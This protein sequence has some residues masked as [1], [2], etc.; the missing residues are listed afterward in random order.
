MSQFEFCIFLISFV[1]PIFEF[2]FSHNLEFLTIW[3]F[4][5]CH[6][7]CFWIKSQLKFCYVGNVGN[8]L[9][10]FFVLSQFDFLTFITIWVCKLKKKFFLI[11]S[12]LKKIRFCHNLSFL[13]HYFNDNKCWPHKFCH[14][15]KN[16][17]TTNFHCMKFSSQKDFITKK[18]I[19]KVFTTTFSFYSLNHFLTIEFPQ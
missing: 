15:K 8:N 16:V 4:K 19:K 18:N 6:N 17:I 11:W 14:N 7:L 5:C 13:W 9:I 3:V 10:F 12:Q 1:L 2:E